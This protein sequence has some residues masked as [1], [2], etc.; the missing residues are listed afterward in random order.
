MASKKLRK[1]GIHVP[2]PLPEP[3]EDAKWTVAFTKPV[4]I[5]LAGSWANKLSV[6]SRDAEKYMVDVAL[7]MPS[8]SS[9]SL[10]S[11]SESLSPEQSCLV[12]ISGERLS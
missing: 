11:E 10:Y 1:Q 8:V 3:T 2:Y 7:E 6:K 5:V 12:I 4:D 9:L